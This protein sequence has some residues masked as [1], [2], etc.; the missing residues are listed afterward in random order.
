MSIIQYFFLGGGEGREAATGRDCLLGSRSIHK[1]RGKSKPFVAQGMEL[2]PGN[3]GPAHSPLG[4]G[5]KAL[6]I[7]QMNYM[8]AKECLHSKI[9]S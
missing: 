2:A 1:W 6:L 4:K 8:W 3:K 7:L 9:I 5:F